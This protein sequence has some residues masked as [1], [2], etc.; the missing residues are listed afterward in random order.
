VKDE[1]IHVFCGATATWR[2]KCY[3]HQNDP[4]QTATTKTQPPVLCFMAL[5]DCGVDVLC[6]VIPMVCWFSMIV[7]VVG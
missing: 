7:K 4:Y 5:Q 2:F 1:E 3:L 6:F